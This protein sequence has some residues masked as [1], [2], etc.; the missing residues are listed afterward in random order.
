[1]SGNPIFVK[2]T[3]P[4]RIASYYM[5]AALDPKKVKSAARSAMRIELKDKE[6][7]TV[8]GTGFSGTLPLYTVSEV[9]KT[10][11]AFVRKRGVDSHSNK[12]VE[13]V[14]GRNWLFVDDFVSAGSTFVRVW[15]AIDDMTRSHRI[16]HQCI[17]AFC[18]ANEKHKGRFYT[19]AD[20]H[21]QFGHITT[22]A[23]DEPRFRTQLDNELAL[24]E[25]AA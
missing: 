24:L 5:T 19:L 11:F 4:L 14:F 10:N 9:F 2:D 1:M 20:L 6:F 17:G 18:Y 13:G 3:E 23:D 7:D 16:G 8:V 25:A 12:P 21:K 15:E 22:L